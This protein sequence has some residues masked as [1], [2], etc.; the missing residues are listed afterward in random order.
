MLSKEM[1]YSDW[2]MANTKMFRILSFRDS[3]LV[4][5][6]PILIAALKFPVATCTLVYLLI[7]GRFV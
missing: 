1:S 4:V 5:L 7:A 6:V 2:Y 3:V